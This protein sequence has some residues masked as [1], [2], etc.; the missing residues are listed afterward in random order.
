MRYFKASDSVALASHPLPNLTRL[1][2]QEVQ[3]QPGRSPLL[4]T[5][6]NSLADWSGTFCIGI[7]RPSSASSAS[8]HLPNTATLR[9][10]RHR[11]HRH[12]FGTTAQ[13]RLLNCV[14]ELSFRDRPVHRLATFLLLS[15]SSSPIPILPPFSILPAIQPVMATTESAPQPQ[16]LHKTAGGNAAFHNFNNDF[17]HIQDPNE[18]RRLALAEIDKAPFG[19]YH[20]RAVVVAGVGFFTDSYD[21]FCVSFLTVMLGITY[22]PQSNGKMPV[23]SDTAIKVATSSGT[24]IGQVGFGALADIVGRKRMYGLELIIIIVATLAQSLSAPSS[25][26][27]IVGLI[28]FWRVIMGIGTCTLMTKREGMKI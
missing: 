10:A 24:V 19:W 20:V 22:W 21:I 23:S 12:L 25:S 18:R 27:S 1:A 15:T 17:A 7:D 14:F 13:L 3:I 26:M 16:F 4:K 2:I 11:P 5:C 8:S 9:A 6:A 28:I